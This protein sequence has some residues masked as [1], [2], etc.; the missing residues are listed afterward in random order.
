MSDN[1]RHPDE[2]MEEYDFSTGVR[3]KHYKS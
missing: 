2:M 1:N 3:G